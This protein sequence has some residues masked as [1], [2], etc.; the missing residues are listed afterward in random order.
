M[1]LS[2]K[3]DGQFPTA[4][5]IEILSDYGVQR[6]PTKENINEILVHVSSTELLSKPFLCLNKLH[7]GMGPLWRAVTCD[8]INALYTL[9]SPTNI[10]VINS[11][12]H[13]GENHQERKV[14]GWPIRYLRSKNQQCISRFLQFCTGSDIVLPYRFIKVRMENMSELSMRPKAQTCFN[15]L[16]IPKN[17]PTQSRLRENVDFYLANPHLWDLTD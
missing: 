7:E 5:L 14:F 2:E 4:E 15:V 1:L 6:C 9:C 12:Q 17:Y 13:D 16:V 8:E 11:L 3:A 10:N